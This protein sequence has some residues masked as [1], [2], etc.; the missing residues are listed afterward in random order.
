ML[1]TH[2]HTHNTLTHRYPLCSPLQKS[3]SNL[4]AEHREGVVSWRGSMAPQAS[5]AESLGA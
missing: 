2:I 3:I 5:A 4:V 1:T